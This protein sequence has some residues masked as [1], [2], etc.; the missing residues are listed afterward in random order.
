MVRDDAALGAADLA[1][2]ANQLAALNGASGQDR[3]AAA[4]V[5]VAGGALSA[6]VPL[7]SAKAATGAKPGA[8]RPRLEWLSAA[9]ASEGRH[10]VPIQITGLHYLILCNSQP[11]SRRKFTRSS[12]PA[13]SLATI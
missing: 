8:A 2:L 12:G 3:G 4:G 13:N 7:M 10:V 5:R 9:L 1:G 6:F 11:I